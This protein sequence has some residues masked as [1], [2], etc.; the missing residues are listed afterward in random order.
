MGNMVYEISFSQVHC[1]LSIRCTFLKYSVKRCCIKDVKFD[2]IRKDTY[3]V[4][5]LLEL[6]SSKSGSGDGFSDLGCAFEFEFIVCVYFSVKNLFRS[7]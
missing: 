7:T 3:L 2:K 6:P 5:C 4:A 1:N